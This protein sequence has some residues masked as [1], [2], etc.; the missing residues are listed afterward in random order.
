MS[1]H[2]DLG[3]ASSVAAKRLERPYAGFHKGSE[4]PHYAA[5]D[6]GVADDDAEFEVDSERLVS[7]E[8]AE[9]DAAY[10]QSET[11]VLTAVRR[12]APPLSPVFT[13]STLSE[14]ALYVQVR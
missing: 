14:I 12:I 10:S 13:G 8:T 11:E 9:D 5:D 2:G 3:A 6:V 7:E 1:C 4:V